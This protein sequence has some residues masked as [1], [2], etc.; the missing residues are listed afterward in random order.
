[1]NHRMNNYMTNYMNNYMNNHMNN[2]MNNYM[3]HHMNHH[4]NHRM[5]TFSIAFTRLRRSGILSFVSKKNG[6]PFFKALLL[7]SRSDFLLI[8]L[9]SLSFTND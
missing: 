1:M 5:K 2:Y 7:M 6:E 9:Q 3:N 4:M 8:I